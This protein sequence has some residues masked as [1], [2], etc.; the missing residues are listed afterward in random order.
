M[1]MIITINIKY[2]PPPERIYFAC[3]F[4]LYNKPLGELKVLQ[5]LANLKHISA[6]DAFA[7]VLKVTS[8]A[9]RACLM[10]SNC[11]PL[12][13]PLW[14]GTLFCSVGWGCRIHWLHLCR[15]VLTPPNDCPGFDT[16]QSDVKVPVMLG[17]SLPLLPGP[18]RPSVVAPDRAL[19]MGWIKLSAYVC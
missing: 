10:L 7:V 15:G 2:L 8:L 9:V 1:M 17:P 4:N 12:E 13:F 16:K 14:L 18:L 6:T 19:S 11:Y 3:I 5:Y